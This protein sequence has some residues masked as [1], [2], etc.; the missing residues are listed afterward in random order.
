[1]KN[2]GVLYS[3]PKIG[4][5]I[6]QLPAVRAIS[7]HHKQPVFFYFNEKIK[8]DKILESQ[9]YIKDIRKNSFHDDVEEYQQRG[10]QQHAGFLSDININIALIPAYVTSTFSLGGVDHN[11]EGLEANVSQALSIALGIEAS[12]INILSITPGSAV[13]NFAVIQ[14]IA[15]GGD[16]PDL[17]QIESDIAT[18]L[19]AALAELPTPIVTTV[20][21]GVDCNGVAAAPP[22]YTSTYFF[23]IFVP[24]LL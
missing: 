11:A 18:G 17:T 22:I 8:L 7:E 24:F 21:I 13:V 15:S 20:E 16:P 5:I 19:A 14:D 1:M 3:A 9:N 12:L 2:V 23:K 6:W 10:G 4:D